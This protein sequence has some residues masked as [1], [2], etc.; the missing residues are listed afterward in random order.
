MGSE[1][2]HPRQ[3]TTVELLDYVAQVVEDATGMYSGSAAAL[4]A[5]AER[6][7]RLL[8]EHWQLANERQQRHGVMPE[9]YLNALLAV[10]APDSTPTRGTGGEG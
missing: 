4:R 7:R 5:R 10:D 1:P 6:L 8:A 9:P 2:N 3:L